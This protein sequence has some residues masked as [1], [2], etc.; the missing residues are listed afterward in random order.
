MPGRS[1]AGIILFVT[2]PISA[3]KIVLMP[4]PRG[5]PDGMGPRAAPRRYRL[6][7]V[8]FDAR[9][10]RAGGQSSKRTEPESLA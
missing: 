1:G 8:R 2:A 7:R 3:S 9:P 6:L 10:A 4:N 5:K